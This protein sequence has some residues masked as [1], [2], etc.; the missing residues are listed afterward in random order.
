MPSVSHVGCS[1]SCLACTLKFPKCSALE[2]NHINYRSNVRRSKQ[3]LIYECVITQL[4]SLLHCIFTHILLLQSTPAFSLYKKLL[5]FLQ[6]VPD[7][8]YKVCT[9]F[10][11]KFYSYGSDFMRKQMS[12][13][14]T[15]IYQLTGDKSG[16]RQNV[17]ASQACQF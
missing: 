11:I 17:F 5:C 10:L 2:I 3:K 13:K 6:N 16:N 14:N 1:F 8:L 15:M 4:V 9:L 7:N 12:G